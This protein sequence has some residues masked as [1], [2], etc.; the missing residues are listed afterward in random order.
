MSDLDD[1]RACASALDFMSTRNIP[2]EPIA[3][4][5]DIGPVVAEWP[6]VQVPGFL[7]RNEQ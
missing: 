5:S 6:S 1:Q 4:R 7:R 2:L 3:D